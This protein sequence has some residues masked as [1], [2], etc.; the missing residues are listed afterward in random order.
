MQPA[1][2]AKLPEKRSCRTDVDMVGSKLSRIISSNRRYEEERILT[3]RK[4]EAGW[5]GVGSG[6]M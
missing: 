2:P 1:P 5:F 4:E 6:A 3:R